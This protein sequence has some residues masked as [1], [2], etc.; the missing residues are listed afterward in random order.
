MLSRATV[1][2]RH[3]YCRHLSLI[4]VLD[5]LSHLKTLDNGIEEQRNG[6]AQQRMACNL[7]TN[8]AGIAIELHGQGDRS[9]RE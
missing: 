1:G 8:G 7:W 6:V 4:K 9:A 5:F 2:R 3:I